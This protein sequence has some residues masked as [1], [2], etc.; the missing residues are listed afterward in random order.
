MNPCMKI[1]L[2]RSAGIRSSQGVR[3]CGMA[4]A[5]IIA[6]HCASCKRPDPVA[7]QAPAG[8]DPVAIQVGKREVRLSELQAEVDFLQQKHNP[9]AAS[10]EAFLEPCVDRLVALE[11]ARALGLEQDMDLRRQWENLLI[12]RLKAS[13]VDATLAE[14]TVTE[15]DVQAYYK[16]NIET[17]ARPAQIQLALLFLKVSEHSD[18][19]AREAVR[20]RM[21]EARAMAASLPAGTHGFGA[22][23]MTYSEEA[24]SRF[25]GGD[26]GWLQAGASA[27]RWPDAVVQAGFALKEKGAISEVIATDDGFYLL[28][29]LDSREAAVR[30]LE[31]RL[32][33]TLEN[34][35]LKEKRSALEAQLKDSWKSESS[36]TLHEEVISKLKF[37]SAPDQPE[38]TKPF[39]KT[40]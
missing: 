35:L 13:Q 7:K 5:A 18:Q 38:A 1:E 37:Q 30:A 17:Y 26:V 27:Y 15:D 34:A 20:L 33:A 3:F 28:K 10:R 21:E 32:R 40:P 9:A 39:P 23:A 36:T 8:Q 2:D 22:E 31:G 25:K 16:R 29:K 14:L 19:A 12:G 6:I 4:S 24:T 11:K